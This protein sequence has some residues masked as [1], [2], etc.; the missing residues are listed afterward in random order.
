MYVLF[1]YTF[2]AQLQLL[3]IYLFFNSIA[4]DIFIYFLYID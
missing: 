2:T 1:M 4:Y 3:F